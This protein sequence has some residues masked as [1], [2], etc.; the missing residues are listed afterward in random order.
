MSLNTVE[1]PERLWRIGRQTNP[2]WFNGPVGAENIRSDTAGNRFDLLTSPIGTLY[3]ASSAEDAYAEAL[4]DLA[5]D[6]DAGHLLPDDDSIGDGCVDA[7]WRAARR[8]CEIELS[9][10]TQVPNLDF[11]DLADS[12]NLAE[13]N[14]ELGPALASLDVDRLNL[15]VVTSSRRSVTRW[16][17][18]FIVS[19]RDA[20]NRRRFAGIRYLSKHGANHECWAVFGGI[21]FS[22]HSTTEPQATDADLRRIA[23]R[24]GLTVH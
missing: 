6:K 16:I 11:V 22:A 4:I 19:Q 18:E 17:A 13:L 1:P 23:K 21:N 12:H 3:A 5:P 14:R 8:L 10:S 2:L 7:N 24:Y 9:E 20:V 15:S